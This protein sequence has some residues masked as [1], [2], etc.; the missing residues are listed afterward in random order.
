MIDLS[1]KGSKNV[2]DQG[3][4]PMDNGQW[5]RTRVKSVARE[6]KSD[7]FEHCDLYPV[8]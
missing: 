2:F 8:K 3:C 6:G 5:P 1:K 4:W 7:S